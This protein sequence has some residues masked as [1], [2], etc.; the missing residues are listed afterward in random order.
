MISY[1]EPKGV[2]QD[3]NSGGQS[4]WGGRRID[5]IGIQCDLNT[6]A[7]NLAKKLMM[8]MLAMRIMNICTIHRSWQ[9]E[10]FQ[11]YFEDF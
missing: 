5:D 7:E 11:S 9:N 8:Q 10:T 1:V 3:I 6:Q 2:Q 4:H